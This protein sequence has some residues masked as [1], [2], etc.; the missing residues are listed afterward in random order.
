MTT[1]RLFL[2]SEPFNQL[3]ER[4]LDSGELVPILADWWERFP[5]PLLYYPSRR[6]MPGPL[7]AFT[8]E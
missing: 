4:Q 8:A 6:H 5:G 1:L 3:E 7:R 2:Q